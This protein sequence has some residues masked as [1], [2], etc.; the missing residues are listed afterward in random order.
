MRGSDEDVNWID[1]GRPSGAW[2]TRPIENYAQVNMRIIPN[3]W[4]RRKELSW[5]IW[6]PSTGK[7]DLFHFKLADQ[8]S[9]NIVL[10]P[11]PLPPTMPFGPIFDYPSN[12]RA[13]PALEGLGNVKDFQKNLKQLPKA[14]A[15]ASKILYLAILRLWLFLDDGNV[16]RN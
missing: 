10:T 11:D 6:Q 14:T 1:D 7:I 8:F 3:T 13:G 2:N 12:R 16:T 5:I 9:S 15:N 4:V